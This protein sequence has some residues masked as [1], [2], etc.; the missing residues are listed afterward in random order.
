[1]IAE[2][3]KK[4]F[5]R[6]LSKSAARNEVGRKDI[7]NTIEQLL[8]WFIRENVDPEFN[9]LYD[10]DNPDSVHSLGNKITTTQELKNLN[11]TGGELKYTEVLRHYENYLHDKAGRK[12]TVTSRQID[13]K[14]NSSHLSTSDNPPVDLLNEGELRKRQMTYHERNPKLRMQ[15]IAIFGWKCAACGFDF[16]KAYGVLGKE[17]IEVHHLHP[18]SQT[19]GSHTVNP[20]KDLVPLCANC[21][22]MIHRLKGEEMSLESLKKFIIQNA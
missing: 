18:I 17:Y 20:A 13:S 3:N 8:P 12:S 4:E 7:L 22:A 5:E 21:H 16:E 6:W 19:E 11:N 1:M 15:C 2:K 14:T 10:Y 9:T